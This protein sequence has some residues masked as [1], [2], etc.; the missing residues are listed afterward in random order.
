MQLKRVAVPVLC[1]N[2]EGWDGK[3]CGK[4]IQEGCGMHIYLMLIHADVR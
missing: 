3:V 4:G 2:L 1:D